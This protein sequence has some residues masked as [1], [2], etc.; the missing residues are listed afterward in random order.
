[1]RD[2]ESALETR[3]LWLARGNRRTLAV[4]GQAAVGVA[5][6][7]WTRERNAM[8]ATRSCPSIHDR[9]GTHLASIHLKRRVRCPQKRVA[10]RKLRRHE[11]RSLG[12]VDT[13]DLDGV[14]RTIAVGEAPAVFDV[15]G[16]G[17]R[18]CVRDDSS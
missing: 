12:R 14:A 2:S 10:M 13:I 1:M 8:S 17:Q 5:A 3:S 11:V 7:L 18:G 4:D 15:L 16:R 9:V 6:L